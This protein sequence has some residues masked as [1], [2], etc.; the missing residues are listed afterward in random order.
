MK[1]IASQLTYLVAERRLRQSFGALAKYL[2][3][4]SVVITIFSV[5]FHVIMLRFEGQEHSWLTGFYWTL[6]V[7]STLGFGD[8]TF[9]SDV[10]RVFSIAVLLS[11]VVLL[12]IVLPFTFIQYFYAPWLEARIRHQAPREVAPGLKGHV[13]ICRHESI[14][15]GLIAKLRFNDIPYVV[16]EPDPV[17]AARMMGD[18]LAV[19]TGETDSGATYERVRVRDA[20]L[21]FANAEDTTNTNITLTV[22]EVS[23][24]VPIVALAED[25]DSVDILELSG[26]SLALPLKQRLGEHLAARTSSGA[27]S[28]HVVGQFRDLLVVE[29]AVKGTP[30]AEATLRETRLREKTGLSVVAVREQAQVRAVSPELSLSGAAVPVALGTAEQVA[31]LR[32][33]L[34]DS[35]AA[36][37]PA[38]VIGAGKVGW[39][40]VA[41]LQH[42]GVPVRVVDK[43]R[44]RRVP[45]GLEPE[46]HIVGDA[47]DR[48]VLLEAGLEDV[49]AVL[50]TTNDDAV[51]IY[52]TVYCRRLKPELRIV[53]RITHERNT[54][55]I[56]RAGADFVLSYAS[57]GREHLASFLLGR[58]PVMLGEGTD[59]FTTPVPDSLV[60]KPLRESGVGER[61]GLV[62]IGVEHGEQ[63]LANPSSGAPLPR[64]ARLLML[65]TADQRRAFSREYD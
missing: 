54:E 34:G 23:P 5:L 15:P 27:G 64:G 50:L 7:M 56:Y 1:F 28:V 18:G 31:A 17:V 3:F 10:G 59:F 43:D 6:T 13:I 4:L 48:D 8:I 41:A 21:V 39:A 19:V 61:T 12:L 26:A 25:E 11:G 33:L 58:D 46:R 16:I 65:G 9:H 51:N 42:R 40:A 57:L 55:A 47:A 49:S 38:L 45:P 60:G 35:G 63:T 30:F 20:R 2:L 53:S 44:R 29:F 14:A 24:D 52:L 62:V 32:G 37:R 22:R 36:V